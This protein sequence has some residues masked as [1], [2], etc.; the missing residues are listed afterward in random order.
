MSSSG[1]DK[2]LLLCEE[3]IK[4]N[5][6]EKMIVSELKHPHRIT[7]ALTDDEG[8]RLVRGGDFGL[9]LI[10]ADITNE[11]ALQAVRLAVSHPTATI[12]F[13]ASEILCENTYV[14]QARKQLLDEG[15]TL[16][17]KPLTQSAFRVALNAADM[18][19]I[20]LCQ[21]KQKLE[22]EK[23]INRSKLV[24]MEVLCMSEE[25]AHK[26]IERE[27]M[28]NGMTRVQTAYDILRTYDY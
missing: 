13:V 28:N 1:I 12:I 15:A 10:T 25:Q 7:K 8:I 27:S 21:L 6:I 22:D 24:L 5:V 4:S 18:S 23:V 2:V 3:N 20:R 26:Y 19:H 9:L 14:A 11:Y 17:V 16:L